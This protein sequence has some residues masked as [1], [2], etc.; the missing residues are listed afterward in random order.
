MT[1]SQGVCLYT[2]G[3]VST[4][5]GLCPLKANF[6]FFFVQFFVFQLFL[7][8]SGLC[9]IFQY[10]VNFVEQKNIKITK[11]TSFMSLSIIYL[12][13]LLNKTHFCTTL[14]STYA[15]LVKLCHIYIYIQIKTQEKYLGTVPQVPFL[16]FCHVNFFS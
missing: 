16:K 13:I 12:M 9:H 14:T 3:C 8:F 5:I 6:D 11:R 4:H 1:T 2:Q 10:R 7:F 15:V